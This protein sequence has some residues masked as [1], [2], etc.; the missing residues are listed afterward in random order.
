[1]KEKKSIHVE[2]DTNILK[3]LKMF[4]V[5]MDISMSKQVSMLIQK[6]LEAHM[7][8]C[9]N[10]NSPENKTHISKSNKEK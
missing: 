6:F 5:S 4:C 10:L 9:I 3:K 7:E 8:N 1:M 2:V